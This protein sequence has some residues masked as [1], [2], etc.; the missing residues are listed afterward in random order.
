MRL[1]RVLVV[2]TPF[3]HPLRVRYS[4]CDQQGVV[5][6]SHYL[7][8]FD[9]SMTE[10]FRAA[11]GGYGVIVERGVDIVVGEAHL[12]Y[13]AP[14]RFDDL[15]QLEVS[16]RRIGDTSLICAHGVRLDGSLLVEGETRHVFVDIASDRKTRAPDW[17][18]DGL[19][20]WTAADD[21]T[22]E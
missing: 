2:A 16:V 17:A 19:A 21:A 14:A 1:Y 22:L 9:I 10:L 12:R 13:L 6:N 11:F 8:W 4:E 3:I 18:R 15:L 5:F 20:P 7:A